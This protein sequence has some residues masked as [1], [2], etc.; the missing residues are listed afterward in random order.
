MIDLPSRGKPEKAVLAAMQYLCKNG[1]YS[2]ILNNIKNSRE[3][4]FATLTAWD[5]MLENA[6]QI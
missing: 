5:A 2:R 3:L 1:R 6:T 4:N